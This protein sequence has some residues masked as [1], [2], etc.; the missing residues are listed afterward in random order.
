MSEKELT[1]LLIEDNPGDARLISYM[2]EE[3]NWPSVHLLHASSLSQGLEKLKKQPV[4][5]VLLDLMLPD[6]TGRYTFSQLFS[7]NSSIPVVVLSGIDDREVAL[8]A[9]KE[10]AQDYLVKGEIDSKLLERTIRYAVERS[11]LLNT[12]RKI[13]QDLR[14]HD[15]LLQ[16]ITNISTTFINISSEQ[17]DQAIEQSLCSIAQFLSADKAFFLELAEGPAGVE[18]TY[19]WTLPAVSATRRV[20][21]ILAGAEFPWILQRLNETSS[22]YFRQLADM[23]TEVTN[24]QNALTEQKVGSFMVLALFHRK[25]TI[26]LLG[27]ATVQ[28]PGYWSRETISLLNTSGEVFY[29]AI[30][31][32]QAEEKI[33]ESERNYRSLLENMDEGL[34]Y[35]NVAG[36]IQFANDSICKMLGYRLE[37]VLGKQLVKDI[38]HEDYRNVDLLQMLQ[39]QPDSRAI[40]QYEVPVKKKN[41][42]K[43]WMIVSKHP[44]KDDTGKNVGIMS[45]LVN[46]TDRKQAEEKLKRVNEELKTFIY[47]ASH[48]LRGP[49]ATVLG[50]TALAKMEITEPVSLKYFDYIGRSTQK[51]DKTLKAL[52]DI[53]TIAQPDEDYTR[54]DF[55]DL[56]REVL[57]N[58]N[59]TNKLENLVV[60]AKVEQQGYFISSKQLLIYI[61]EKLIENA[62]F[63]R[64][65]HIAEPTL[66]IT[67]SAD[68]EDATI[69]LEDNGIGI[70]EAHRSKVFTMFFKG[71]EKSAGSGLGLY[72]VDKLVSNLNGSISLSSEVGVGTRFTLQLRSL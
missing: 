17:I 61:F 40:A 23:P 29:R 36:A 5:L 32:K 10:G 6:S 35:V 67:V 4:D 68:D 53:S 25:R 57:D 14:A 37:E 33:K 12:Q 71:I 2:V 48:D 28:R 69:V 44:I 34:I 58:M 1:V 65:E 45:T 66:Q 11:R 52:M 46:I 50:V 19:E 38:F 27:L 63:F 22:V 54:I 18:H 47:R 24:L 16:L 64:K 70:P 60:R 42:D 15:Q 41:G 3:I 49:L 55:E 13:Q 43:L 39:H 26:A 9:I 56:I 51:L 31:K 30:K 21:D 72:I 62:V 20:A 7:A 8:E 59:Y